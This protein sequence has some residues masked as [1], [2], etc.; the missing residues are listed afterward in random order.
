MSSNVAHALENPPNLSWR[1]PAAFPRSVAP[2]CA[3]HHCWRR[4]ATSES[5]PTVRLSGEGSF[6]QYPT[7]W[8][9]TSYKWLNKFHYLVRYITLVVPNWGTTYP[10][11]GWSAAPLCRNAWPTAEHPRRWFGPGRVKVLK[12]RKPQKEEEE[13]DGDD[14]DDDDG[15]LPLKCLE[16]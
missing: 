6:S 3:R 2:T 8:C 5:H 15:Y 4:S 10:M 7:R 1:F 11:V 14:D 13:E 12:K 9:P 16:T